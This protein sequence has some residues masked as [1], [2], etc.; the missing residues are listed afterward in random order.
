[1]LKEQRRIVSGYGW[2][3]LCLISAGAIT[4]LTALIHGKLLD[5]LIVHPLLAT[6]PPMRPSARALA[7]PLLHVSTV[8]WLTSG[9]P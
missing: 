1:M 8:D 6:E 3:D 2:Q 5:P 9:K 7:R 4:V